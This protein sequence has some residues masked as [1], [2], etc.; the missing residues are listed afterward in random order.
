MMIADVLLALAGFVAGAVGGVLG[1]GG[2][3][4]FVPALTMGLGVPQTVAQG[5]SLAAIVPTS[6]VGAVTADREGNVARSQLVV[7]SVLGAFGAAGGALLAVVLPTDVL[8]RVFG[9]LLLVSAWRL[10]RS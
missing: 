3:L 9:A 6:L 2:G 10:W 1:V 7:M 5:T 4:V 8:V